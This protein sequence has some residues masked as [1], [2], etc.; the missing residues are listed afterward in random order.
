MRDVIQLAINA[1]TSLGPSPSCKRGDPVHEAPTPRQ[2]ESHASSRDST[3]LLW[4]SEDAQPT[5]AEIPTRWKLMFISLPGRFAG[6]PPRSRQ[7]IE[8]CNVLRFEQ[9]HS[10]KLNRAGDG[11]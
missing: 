4:D 8:V 3:L 1:E 7:A 2:W 11:G 10:P 6:S 9:R 5:R